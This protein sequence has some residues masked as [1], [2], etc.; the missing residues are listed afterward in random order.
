MTAIRTID[1]RMLARLLREEGQ[2]YRPL[3]ASAVRP[4]RRRAVHLDPVVEGIEVVRSAHTP[5]PLRSET[6]ID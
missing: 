3:T 5:S 4:K 1:I 6:R 2:C